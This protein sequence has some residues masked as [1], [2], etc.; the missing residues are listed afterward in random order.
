MQD[1]LVFPTIYAQKINL[2]SKSLNE[3][4]LM[5]LIL[6]LFTTVKKPVL[7]VQL[8]SERDKTSIMGTIIVRKRYYKIYYFWKIIICYLLRLN[9][10]FSSCI[11]NF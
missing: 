1:F 6:I 7:W 8:L 2:K 9:T 10:E 5:S 11:E 4:F 3:N